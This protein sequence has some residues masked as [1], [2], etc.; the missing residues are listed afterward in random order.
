MVFYVC[1]PFR[2]GVDAGVYVCGRMV[3]SNACVLTLLAPDPGIYVY[4]YA[5]MRIAENNSIND[6]SIIC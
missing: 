4:I 5:E 1:N 3:N 6:P 2:P